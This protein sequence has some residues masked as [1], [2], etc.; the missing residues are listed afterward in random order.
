MD[1][2]EKNKTEKEMEVDESALNEVAGGLGHSSALAT[3]VCY[4]CRKG[5][6]CRHNSIELGA[7]MDANGG[8]TLS[9]QC[10]WYNE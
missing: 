6:N 3:V 2:E 9:I 7:Y 8:V 1:Y 4:T 5:R 10:P